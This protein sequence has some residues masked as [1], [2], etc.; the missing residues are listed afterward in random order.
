M[1]KSWEEIKDEVISN[2]I[3]SLEI[4]TLKEYEK[5]QPPEFNSLGN[6]SK[7]NYVQ[8]RIS[9]LISDKEAV[10]K[11]KI[12]K[13]R[14]TS[15]IHWNKIAAYAAIASAILVCI[16]IALSTYPSKSQRESEKIRMQQPVQDNQ[17]P[18][19][20]RAKLTSSLSSST[21]VPQSK[22]VK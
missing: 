22:K 12:D 15:S 14:Y 21:R 9:R 11:A 2:K 7:V 1:L 5:V 16:Q 3:E 17:Q 6:I 18:T 10:E 4:E 8:Q 19:K 20:S 13:A